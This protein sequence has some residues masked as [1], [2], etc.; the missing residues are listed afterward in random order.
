MLRFPDYVQVLVTGGA[1]FLGSHLC[2]RLIGD[3]VA[4]SVS[5]TSIRASR[6]VALCS[7]PVFGSFGTT[8]VP[9]LLEVNPYLQPRLRASPTLPFRPLQPRSQSYTAPSTCRSR[10]AHAGQDLRR[11]TAR[12]TAIRT[13]IR[14]RE[15]GTRQSDRSLALDRQAC[16]ETRFFRTAA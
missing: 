16:F 1:G 6:N 10:Q 4:V 11:H 12:S 15:P 2:D 3:G 13:F 8:S 5:T 14:S 9:I 7:T